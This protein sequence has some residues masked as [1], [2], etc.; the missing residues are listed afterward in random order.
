[1]DLQ[2]TD[3]VFIVTGGT[4][5]LGL[6]A[7]QALLAEGARVLVTGRSAGKAD[8][9]RASLGGAADR[10]ARLEGDNAD[11]GLPSRLRDAVLDRWGRLDGMLVS[12]GGPPPG[13]ALATDDG[14]WRD[15]FD[16]VFLG[17]VRLVRELAPHVADGGAIA[18]LLAISAKEASPTIP[19]SNGLRPGLAMLVK[20]FAGELGPRAVR[21]NALLPN[22]FATDRTRKLL[23]NEPPPVDGIALRRMGEPAELGRMAAVLLSPVAS[24]VTGAAISIDGGQLKSL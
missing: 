22:L 20:S 8:E 19:I 6:A 14:T 1:M 17:T 21:I 11:E 13:R 9:L 3:K 4:D 7:A 18:L 15:A 16:S 23:G 10:L 2:L 12:V 5:G 24:Y